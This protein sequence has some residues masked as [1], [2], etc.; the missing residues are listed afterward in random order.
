M[1]RRP[2]ELQSES[3]GKARARQVAQTTTR[4]ERVSATQ[5]DVLPVS[6][7]GLGVALAIS[8]V[9][10]IAHA[11]V[12]VGYTGT[13]FGGTPRAIPG[14]IDFEDFDE[15][16]ENIS[17]DVDD[18]T[19]NFGEGGCAANAYREGIHPQLCQTNTN[20]GENDVFTAGPMM[21]TKYPSDA[22][23]QSIYI[24]YT[25]GVDWVKI[26]VDVKQ[27]GSYKLST[28]W[29]SEAGGAGVI[30]PEISFNDVVK[31]TPALAGTG[32]YHNWIAY[33]DFATIELEAGV[34]VLKFL[35]KTQHLNYDYLQFSLVLPGGGVD[36]GSGNAG[37]SGGAGAG[38]GAG[39]AG[40]A[41][42]GASGAGGAAGGSPGVIPFP[43]A[44]SAGSGT[45]TAGTSSGVGT[46]GTTAAAGAAPT[47]PMLTGTN[48]EQE[49]SCSVSSS[50]PQ[51]GWFSLLAVA[52]L[53]AGLLR[54]RLM[55][56]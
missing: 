29:A 36:D 33:P 42:G 43:V 16:G 20:P 39:A 40:A 35:A 27:A 23:P 38:G 19:G 34:Q 52:T 6:K 26:T 5:R 1:V 56:L 28:T 51:T 30:N 48:A 31:A 8:L 3:P 24:G 4:L 21:G 44:G 12:P 7:L 49:S 47:N 53:S 54:R 18:H 37:G 50:Q 45:A 46:A 41:A 17:W 15:G 13:P 55:R 11:A 10:T 14:R 9:G 32:G 22:M 2:E 25:H